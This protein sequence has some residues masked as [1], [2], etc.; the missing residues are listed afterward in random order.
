MADYHSIL[1]KAV[2][3]LDPNTPRA[4]QRIYDRA[5]SA[6]RSTVERTVP[7]IY[8]ADVATAKVA[9]EAAITK[10][11]AEAVHRNSP[12]STAA[13][14]PLSPGSEPATSAD[15]REA[16]LVRGGHRSGTKSGRGTWL[17]EV[18][19]R[20]SNGAGDGRSFASGRARGDDA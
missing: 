9:L 13:A 6:M 8:A 19:E 16:S 20:A 7:P 15:E 14:P 5:R 4:R 17:T 10:V 12:A 18:L 2:D 1:A 3:A 11:E